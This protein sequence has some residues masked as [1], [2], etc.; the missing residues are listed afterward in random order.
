[1]IYL[2]KC[3]KNGRDAQDL[4]AS[5]TCDRG[6]RRNTTVFEVKENNSR[7]LSHELFFCLK[8]NN[9]TKK[10]SGAPGSDTL[11]IADLSPP[12]WR[13]READ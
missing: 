5:S 11:V 12:C 1:M 10:Q 13:Q 8:L 2:A 7:A 3:V 4:S 6:Q 9:Y